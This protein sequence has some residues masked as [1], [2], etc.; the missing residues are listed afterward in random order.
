MA[1]TDGNFAEE[2]WIPAPGCALGESR[3]TQELFDEGMHFPQMNGK[4]YLL[5]KE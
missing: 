3:M 4:L 2:L 5:V 1:Y